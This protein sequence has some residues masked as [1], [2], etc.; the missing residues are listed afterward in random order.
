[1]LLHLLMASLTHHGPKLSPWLVDVIRLLCQSSAIWT[2][3]T[4]RHE[5]QYATQWNAWNARVA[6]CRTVADPQ[7]R[8]SPSDCIYTSTEHF[9]LVDPSV[10]IAF[11]V[12]VALGQ[13]D[14][15]AHVSHHHRYFKLF[16]SNVLISFY[17][18][19]I[20][21]KE[22]L[23]LIFLGAMNKKERTTLQY[24]QFCWNLFISFLQTNT[25]VI[26]VHSM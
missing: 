4:S 19:N 12:N 11:S 22:T 8:C 1:M 6:D 24:W 20:K 17:W 21:S 25:F 9:K 14:P 3:K 23:L 26:T 7:T 2:L 15:R 18:I 13:C 16:L 10:Q 5:T